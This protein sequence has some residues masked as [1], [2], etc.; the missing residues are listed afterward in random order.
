MIYYSQK[1]TTC[2]NTIIPRRIKLLVLLLGFFIPLIASCHSGDKWKRRLA[3]FDKIDRRNPPGRGGIVFVGSSSISR[4]KSLNEDFSPH[5]VLN[6]GLAA[7]QISD[8]TSFTD[9]LIIPYHPRMIVMYCEN[10]V[11]AGRTPDQVL[12]D[13]DAFVK[14]VRKELPRVIIAFI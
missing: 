6:R 13:F 10:D 3:K 1:S 11:Y 4:W 9:R 5:Y 12:A 2:R 8:V 7:S 14:H